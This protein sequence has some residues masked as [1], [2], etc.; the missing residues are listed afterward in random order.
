MYVVGELVFVWWLSDEDL[1]EIE[2]DKKQEKD[3]CV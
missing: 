3:E 2:I 1:G